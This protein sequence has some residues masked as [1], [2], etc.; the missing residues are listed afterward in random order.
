VEPIRREWLETIARHRPNPER[1]AS[2]R[3]WA[4]SLERMSRDE[5]RA[6]QSEKLRV[7]VRYAH[8]SIPFYR[9]KFDAIGLDPRDVGGV[10]DLGKIPLTT[11]GEMA[12]D[13]AEH[14]PWGTYTAV[15]D[16]RWLESGWQIFA[17]SGTTVRP[18]IFRYTRF[19]RDTWAWA[20]AR[21]LWAMG[22]RPGRDS[23]LI[24]FGYGPHVWL[25]GVH[26]AFNLMGIPIITAGGLDSRTRAR[27]I[28]RYRPTILCCTPSYAIFLAS[29]LRESGADPAAT[30]VRYLFCAGEPGFSVPAT[31]R[32]LEETWSAELHEFYGC[33]EAAPCA[34][35]F[36]CTEV[37]R[38][39]EGPVSTHLFE[40]GQIWETVDPARL[41]PTQRGERGLSV[42]TNLCSEASPQ[43]R[44]LVGDF[45]TLSDELCECGRTH[46]RAIGG[47]R[48]RA[49][50]M[51]NVRGVT[52]FPASI[53]DAVRGV[54]DAGSE[55]EI[56]LTRERSLDVLTVRVEGRDDL[57]AERLASLSRLVESEIVGACELRPVVEILPHG[58]LPR[59]EFKAK[60]VRDLR[61]RA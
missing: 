37:A 16:A 18:R 2:E 39:K 33:T 22:F 51:L 14:P 35:G 40:D 3:F 31:R 38:R 49:D 24:A 27:F 61:D 30:S 45:T 12:E 48:G 20:D 13:L 28:D 8:A 53:E 11:K 29:V 34:G 36:T 19:D 4:E 59:A 5:I 17:S 15:D 43:L 52:L 46:A 42:V 55:F 57:P 6:L 50:D 32:I 9:R 44:F 21:A 58:T 47:F 54:P 60:R 56:V 23:A 26:Y 1:A 7:A 41:E 10:E 25:W